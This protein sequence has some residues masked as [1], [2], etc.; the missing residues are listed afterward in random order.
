MAARVEATAG[1][2]TAGAAGAKS[3]WDEDDAGVE[4]EGSEAA[5]GSGRGAGGREDTPAAWMDLLGLGCAGGLAL[6]PRAG[7]VLLT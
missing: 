5:G 2:A 3:V 1:S 6:G 4:G 7:H